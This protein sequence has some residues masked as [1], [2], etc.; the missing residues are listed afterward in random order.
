MTAT[1]LAQG[2]AGS[3]VDSRSVAFTTRLVIDEKNG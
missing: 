2:G 3:L 1:M